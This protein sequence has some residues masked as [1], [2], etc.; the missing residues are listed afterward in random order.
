MMTKK[1][2]QEMDEDSKITSE[3][4]VLKLVVYMKTQK[5]GSRKISKVIGCSQSTLFRLLHQ[6]NKPS[7]EFTKQSATLIFLGYDD[8][9]TLTNEQ[10][11]KIS[12]ILGAV[13]GGGIGISS[14]PLI[15][16]VLGYHGLAAACSSS[17]CRIRGLSV[18]SLVEVPLPVLP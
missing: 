5:L 12:E 10:K 4:C 15:I 14:I 2:F 1:G 18:N 11:E 9:K 7:E 17:L 13:V 6:M 8:Y 16:S 3:N